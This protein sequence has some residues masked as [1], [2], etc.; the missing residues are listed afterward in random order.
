MMRWQNG[1]SVCPSLSRHARHVNLAHASQK[2]TS[3]RQLPRVQIRNEISSE[4]G[5][6]R[7]EVTIDKALAKGTVLDLPN[8][9]PARK[10]VA[11]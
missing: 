5:Q 3:T 10:A 8:F 7:A 4:V 2:S 11:A 6:L 9:L 1:P